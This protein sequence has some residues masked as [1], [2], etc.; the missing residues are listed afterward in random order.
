MSAQL[1]VSFDALV[2]LQGKKGPSARKD[3]VGLSLQRGELCFAVGTGEAMITYPLNQV[4]RCHTTML[5]KG[6]VTIEVARSKMEVQLFLCSKADPSELKRLL[7]AVEDA[8]RRA[9]A[10]G[11]RVL[12][13]T[14][15]VNLLKEKFPDQLKK[16]L[17]KLAQAANRDAPQ[18]NK[19]SVRLMMTLDV[20]RDL[21]Q[22]PPSSNDMP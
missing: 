18:A 9:S 21:P 8:K 20:V 1:T 17:Q 2:E 12:P 15:A 14:E 7:R 19:G 5:E 11:A 3:A 6:K 16:Q 10:L 22:Q 13:Q 4:V